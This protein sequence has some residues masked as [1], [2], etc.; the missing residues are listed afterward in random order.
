M[1]PARSDTCKKSVAHHSASPV[2]ANFYVLLGEVEHCGCLCSAQLVDVPQHDHRTVLIRKVKHG[3]FQKLAELGEGRSLFRIKRRLNNTH[4]TFFI[5]FGVL[6]LLAPIAKA[7]ATQCFMD[8]NAR[9]PCRKRRA[10]GKLVEVLV[11]PNVGILYYIFRFGIVAQNRARNT[12]EPLVIAA[13][14]YLV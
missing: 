9:Q 10:S 4:R 3:F 8:R 13:H 1:F 11:C 12:I 6:Q 2:Q 14:D 7:E 5:M